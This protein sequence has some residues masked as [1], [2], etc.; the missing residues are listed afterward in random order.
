MFSY[1]MVRALFWEAGLSPF[2][3]K[4]MQPP[5]IQLLG[6]HFKCKT[7]VFFQAFTNRESMG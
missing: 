2:S 4:R 7:S 5:G 1:P 3:L 6:E